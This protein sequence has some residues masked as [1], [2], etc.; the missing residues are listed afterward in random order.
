MIDR[1]S[2][3]IECKTEKVWFIPEMDIKDISDV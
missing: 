2:F 1:D 3:I